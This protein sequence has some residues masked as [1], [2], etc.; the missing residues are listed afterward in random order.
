VL[1][2]LVK[3]YPDL[4]ITALV[5]NPLHVKPVRDLGVGV[6]EGSFS[7]TDLITSQARAAEITINSADSDN[8]AVNE[9]ILA[10]Q[11]AR[12][13]EDGKPPPIL[14]HTSGVAVFSDGGKE[15]KHDAKSKVWDDSVEADIRSITTQMLHGQVDVPIFKAS[16]AGHTESYIICPAAVVGP[17]RGPVP[18]STV[19]FFFNLQLILALKKPV[20]VGEGENLFY[21]VLL[22]D[23]VDLYRRIFARILS[24]EDAQ[25][26]PYSRYYIGVSNPISWKHI[27]TV[28]GSVLARFGKLEDGTPQSTPSADTLPPP[29]SMFLGASQHLRGTRAEKMG[30]K[31]RPVVLEDFA[32]EGTTSAL[33][34]LA[35]SQT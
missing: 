26:S 32:D 28:F 24:R 27:M 23:L 2:D 17:P 14:F 12:V 29:A 6:V 19:F 25:A 33:A 13:V 16:E 11:K 10:G 7:D 35:S 31:P 1:A 30:W 22:D 5:R 3:T 21:A 15:G 9:A 18:A 34:K 20:Y 8:T 4:K